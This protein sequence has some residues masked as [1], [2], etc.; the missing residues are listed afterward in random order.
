VEVNH[1]LLLSYLQ[2]GDLNEAV[3]LGTSAVQRWP[4]DPQLQHWL[5]LA[6]FKSG[7]KRRGG[8]GVKAC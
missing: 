5:G 2:A 8:A 1:G 6:Y 3:Q 4:D 7:R